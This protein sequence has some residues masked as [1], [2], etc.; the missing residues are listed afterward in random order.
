MSDRPLVV[1]EVSQRLSETAA[2]P[3]ADLG[4]T[5]A[6]ELQL[7]RLAPL[8][9]LCEP[10]VVVATTDLPREDAV[11]AAAERAG[12]NVVRAHPDDVLSWFTIAH[13]RFGGSPIVRLVN[14]APLSDPY[15]VL[16]ALRLH[17]D[18]DAHHAGN[19]ASR[20]YPRGL[21]VEVLSPRALAAAEVE[22]TSPTERRRVTRVLLRHPERHRLANLDSG[23]D[24]ANVDWSVRDLGS[25]NQ[26]RT[27]LTMVADPVDTSWSRILSVTG[28]TQR[29]LPGTPQLIPL[30]SAEPGSSPWVRRWSSVVDG[31]V[32][33][34]ATVTIADDE[35]QR[36]VDAPKEW[37]VRTL[38]A[39]FE[40]LADDPQAGP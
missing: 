13:A 30:P 32:V 33:G 29:T 26:L 24:A 21:E 28:K 6:L 25:L 40:L 8:K 37:K 20:S 2:G 5:T 22:A 23:I 19:V 38:D 39:L 31:V 16:A 7:R 18:S 17:A 15:L 1:I 36:E 11:V 3:L 14:D 9:A 27:Q 35:V 34:T 10:I 4:F 12:A